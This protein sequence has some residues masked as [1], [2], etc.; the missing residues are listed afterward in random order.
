MSFLDDRV[1]NLNKRN[2]R[3]SNYGN[4]ARPHVAGPHVAG[5]HVAR[6]H[7]AGGKLSTTTYLCYSTWPFNE[8][9]CK[10]LGYK[11]CL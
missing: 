2:G 3:T 7:V 11:Y 8:G 6:P 5:P 1:Y 10:L 9:C 4:K